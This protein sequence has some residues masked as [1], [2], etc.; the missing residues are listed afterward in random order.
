M[1]KAI[2]LISFG[3]VLL[4]FLGCFDTTVRLNRT[5]PV[6]TDSGMTS[7]TATTAIK[8]T[9][10]KTTI[11]PDTTR[12]TE[13]TVTVVPTVTRTTSTTTAV[14]TTSTKTTVRPTATRTSS[15]K[16]VQNDSS[17]SH[18]PT[19][20]RKQYQNE[21]NKPILVDGVSVDIPVVETPA[22]DYFHFRSLLEAVGARV[23]WESDTTGV[24][25][26]RDQKPF[27][28]DL[29]KGEMWPPNYDASWPT[30]ARIFNVFDWRICGPPVSC[31]L[32]EDEWFLNNHAV[33]R[34][35]TGVL[36]YEKTYDSSTDSILI[37]RLSDGD[38]EW[39]R[40]PHEP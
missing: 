13:T 15:T 5:E 34:L 21:L 26:S 38:W 25:Y 4:L 16:F 31:Y 24:V 20:S 17:T 27:T 10:T 22:V 36:G 3:L 2:S 19:T 29:E 14:K 33:I 39:Y 11:L 9:L 8:T 7:M 32:I 1:R 12:T 30:T 6:S 18:Y 37:I 35:L 28:F 40:W 23:E